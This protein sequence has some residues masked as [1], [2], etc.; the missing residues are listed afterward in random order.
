MKR[1]LSLRSKLMFL[2]SIP[3]CCAIGVSWFLALERLN[4]LK[5]FL[6]FKDAMNLANSLAD[7]N[8]A[9]STELA[10]AWCW[11]PT[12]VKENGIEVVQKIRDTLAANGKDADTAYAR[13]KAIEAEMNLSKYDQHLASVLAE[14]DNAYGGLLEHRAR[15]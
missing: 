7:L 11:T 8:E 9:N 1:S 14:V 13:L 15:M 5:E 6:A 4:A 2:C 3:L 12:A 10:N